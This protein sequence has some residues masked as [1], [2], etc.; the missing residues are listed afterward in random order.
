M[1][2]FSIS[3]KKLFPGTDQHSDKNTVLMIRHKFQTFLGHCS[4][5]CWYTLVLSHDFS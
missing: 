5:W 2:H 1:L 4:M 3:T